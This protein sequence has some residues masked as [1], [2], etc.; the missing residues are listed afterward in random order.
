MAS[1]CNLFGTPTRFEMMGGVTCGAQRY[2]VRNCSIIS[3]FI[4]MMNN[5][6]F[7]DCV[8][9][10]VSAYFFKYFPCIYSIASRFLLFQLPRLS[11]FN[12]TIYIAL[13]AR[14]KFIATIQTMLNIFGSNICL[15]ATFSRAK[16][17]S[18]VTTPFLW[19]ERFMAVRTYLIC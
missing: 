4:N 5:Q 11:T 10:T 16:F 9:S 3:V 6:Q 1:I 8:I 14:Y 17:C 15:A 18:F 2:Q 13:V 19:L 7:W 12:R